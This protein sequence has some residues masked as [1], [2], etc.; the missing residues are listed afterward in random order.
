M[1]SRAAWPLVFV[2]RHIYTSNP[3]YL[4]SAGT[5]LLG[6][7]QT[8]EA[9]SAL[10]VGWPLMGMIAS[11]MLLLALTGYVVV[12]LGRVWDDAR[13]ILLTLVLVGLALAV[14]ID[15]VTV[16][17]P[18]RGAIHI[19]AGLLFTS[20]VMELLLIG[21]KIR[22]AFWY[23]TPL[24]LIL[25]LLFAYP[26]WLGYCNSH[27]PPWSGSMR[28][29][30]LLFPAVAGLTLLSLWPAARLA[31]RSDP[32]SG[33]PW[34]W[35]WYPWSLFIALGVALSLR[36]AALCWGFDDTQGG[37]FSWKPYLLI[38]ILLS[39]LVLVLEAAVT[40]QNIYVQRIALC[41]PILLLLLALPG[42]RLNPSA[43]LLL[44]A[45]RWHGV[46]PIQLTLYLL[47]CYYGYFWIR[48]LQL[49]ELGFIAS[50]LLSSVVNTETV[51]LGG[52]TSPQSWPLDVL[53]I[54]MLTIG[55]LRGT[56]WRVV[57]GAILAMQSVSMRP[58]IAEPFLPSS[59][60]V[61]HAAVLSA[62]VIGIIMDDVLARAIRSVA[63]IAMPLAAVFAALAYEWLFPSIGYEMHRYYVIALAV[64]SLLYWF[65]F[66]HLR[67]VLSTF[68]CSV[69][70]GFMYAR[71][72][73]DVVRNTDLEKGIRWII[74]GLVMLILAVLISSAKGGLMRRAWI[75]LL[76][77]NRSLRH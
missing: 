24:Y 22:L 64:I 42:E 16:N 56:G 2:W 60:F 69:T 9:E 21:L 44:D 23:R 8:V 75:A 74:A 63:H 33:T 46:S 28:E 59:Y 61:I 51:G 26:I 31:G 6:F 52:F 37:F 70:V 36:S 77:A 3:F 19:A 43:M 11:Y 50:G 1:N 34:N 5:V 15:Q 68:L 76:R 53:S 13:S 30:L 73:Y 41:A 67:Y 39:G 40:R 58:W 10:L 55:I 7:Q 14:S 54:L 32:P 49:A 4:I 38:P 66:F 25:V 35:P 29:G 45:L 65:S 72:W 48:G 20:A 62:F 27:V 18:M 12:R 47:L 71:G 57:I 17:F